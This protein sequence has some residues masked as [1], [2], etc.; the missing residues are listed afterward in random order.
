VRRSQ[1]SRSV[2]R[3][4]R[5][6]QFGFR[7]DN[8]AKSTIDVAATLHAVRKPSKPSR[9]PVI[10]SH[11]RVA[12]VSSR[13]GGRLAADCCLQMVALSLSLFLRSHDFSAVYPYSVLH[14][15]NS[16]ITASAIRYKL[17][18]DLLR[19]S[20]YGSGHSSG[21]GKKTKPFRQSRSPW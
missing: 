14:Q 4:C 16:H 12:L 10:R 21:Q 13:P 8:L 15:C 1:S 3:T 19:R 11:A 9:A 6:M 20:R 2:F 18:L 5:R 17:V 7:I